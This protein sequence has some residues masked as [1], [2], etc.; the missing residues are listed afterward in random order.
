MELY[1]RNNLSKS[2][3]CAKDYLTSKC[4]VPHAFGGAIVEVLQQLR[5]TQ[6]GLKHHGQGTQCLHKHR[7]AQQQQCDNCTQH[8]EAKAEEQVVLEG[9]PLPEVAKVQFWRGD[10]IKQIQSNNL[11]FA[12]YLSPVLFTAWK[13]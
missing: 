3:N 12:Q 4:A 13:H 7:G 11:T 1:A 5:Q 8:S 2:P 6:H 10:R 9:A